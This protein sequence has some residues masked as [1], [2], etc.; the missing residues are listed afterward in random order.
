MR[1]INK[2]KQCDCCQQNKKQML[3]HA[4]SFKLKSYGN[5]KLNLLIER[6]TSKTAIFLS[7]VLFCVFYSLT[8][9]LH[10][11]SSTHWALLSELEYDDRKNNIELMI[12]SHGALTLYKP[13]LNSHKLVDSKN[14][15]YYG[16]VTFSVSEQYVV[17]SPQYSMPKDTNSSKLAKKDRLVQIS[18]QED[19]LDVEYSLEL[20][21]FFT[22]DAIYLNEKILV[23]NTQQGYLDI[24]SN[25]FE[26]EKAIKFG[27]KSHINSISGS[28][29][30]VFVLLNQLSKSSIEVLDNGMNKI[31]SVLNIGKNSHNLI[32]KTANPNGNVELYSLS[33]GEATLVK[34]QFNLNNCKE[35]SNNIVVA[36]KEVLFNIGSSL[37]QYRKP[38]PKGLLVMNSIAFFGVSEFVPNRRQRAEVETTLFAFDIMTKEIILARS[39]AET[40]SIG[41]I[42]VIGSPKFSLKSTFQEVHVPCSSL[43]FLGSCRVDVVKEI[44]KVNSVSQTQRMQMLDF[45]RETGISSGLTQDGVYFIKLPLKLNVTQLQ[46]DLKD[47]NNRVKWTYREDVNNYF[48]LLVTSEGKLEDESKVGPFRPIDNRISSMKYTEKVISS[49]G[50]PVGRSRYMMLPGGSSVALHKDRT[51]HIYKNKKSKRQQGVDHKLLNNAKV[52]PLAGYWGRRFRVHIPIESNPKVQFISEDVSLYMEPGYAYLFDNSGTHTVNNPSKLDRSHL[53]IDTVGSYQLF[54]LVTASKVIT[55]GDNYDAVEVP[56]LD[57]YKEKYNEIFHDD[58]LKTFPDILPIAAAIQEP[59]RIYYEN[60]IDAPVYVPVRSDVANKYLTELFEEVG[61]ETQQQAFIDIKDSFLASYETK[62][63]YKYDIRDDYIQ[64]CRDVLQTF[65]HDFS[66]V[67][68]LMKTKN[69]FQINMFSAVESLTKNLFYECTGPGFHKDFTRGPPC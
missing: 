36:N 15:V 26:F 48:I 25:L 49:L 47:L 63:I 22:H 51:K 44:E 16:Q 62:C 11:R 21:S 3:P 8:L 50:T 60:W 61:I 37:S 20:Q 28:E 9:Q 34:I 59:N 58:S 38:F 24:Y 17:A 4:E 35:S 6:F 67:E 65:I 23:A 55:K 66:N 46:E 33:S 45:Y 40:G 5:R 56:F 54:Q 52:N 18:L 12:S 57:F 2:L 39:A 10:S 42:N 27:K 1:S 29:G 19:S 7:F 43:Q 30:L 53:V 31:C 64:D 32:V 41:L 69:T 68:T 14:G 13:F